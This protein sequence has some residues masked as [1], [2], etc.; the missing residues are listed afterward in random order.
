MVFGLFCPTCGSRDINIHC[1]RCVSTVKVW[2]NVSY[3]FYEVYWPRLGD[4]RKILTID[5]LHGA[6][7]RDDERGEWHLNPYGLAKAKRYAELYGM[8]PAK[9]RQLLLNSPPAPGRS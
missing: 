5:I 1:C 9:I 7:A 3:M 4:Y 2:E 8:S 6:K